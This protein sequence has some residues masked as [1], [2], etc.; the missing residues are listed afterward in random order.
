MIVRDRPNVPA[1]LRAA[2]YDGTVFC[3]PPTQASLALVDLAS[4]LVLQE[5]G[6]DPRHAHERFSDEEFFMRIG[7]LRKAIYT[8]SHAHDL[9]AD[10]AA[11][12]GFAPDETAF[13]PARLRVIS[14]GAFDNPRAAPVYYPHRDTWYGHPM[15]VVTI[16]TALDDLDENETFVFYPNRFRTPVDNDSEV[17]DYDEWVSRGWSLK[18]G[19]QDRDASLHARYPSVIGEADYGKEE[20]FSCKRGEILLFA[21]AHFHKTLPQSLG[22]TRFS[23][24]ARLVHLGDHARGLGAPNVDGRSRGSALRDYVQPVVVR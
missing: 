2:L 19:W 8:E 6:A 13:D 14:H 23:L 21:G 3:L 18:I 10:M 15:S 11:S 12:V 17:F 9:L 5:L 1:T 7:R 22:R 20:G 24:D 4:T 16:W